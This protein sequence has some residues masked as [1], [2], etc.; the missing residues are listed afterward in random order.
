M[1]CLAVIL[2]S[3]LFWSCSEA[4]KSKVNDPAIT[5]DTQFANNLA[6]IPAESGIAGFFNVPEMLTLSVIDSST[7]AAAAEAV[8]RAYKLL[9]ADLRHTRA[10]QNGAFGQITYTNDTAN[11][12]FECFALISQIPRTNPQHA[13]VVILEADHMLAYNYYGPYQMLYTAYDEIRKYIE[14]NQLVQTGPMR[15][16]Y[17]TDPRI[18]PDEEKRRTL[19]LLPV[20][21]VKAK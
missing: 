21:R 10:F 13:Q 16:Y 5:A 7:A 8:G 2:I 20:R 3:A 9:E 4:E 18:Q 6:T 12:K 17:V 14:V 19:I 11:F 1:R 15:E